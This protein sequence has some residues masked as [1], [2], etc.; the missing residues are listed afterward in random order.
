MLSERRGCRFFLRVA[1]RNQLPCPIPQPCP[2]SGESSQLCNGWVVGPHFLASRMC[3][4]I[5]VCI[6]FL[7]FSQRQLHQLF[8]ILLILL[9]I[10]FQHLLTVDFYQKTQWF[11]MRKFYA[12]WIYSRQCLVHL[13]HRRQTFF[14]ILTYFM[15]FHTYEFKIINLLSSLLLLISSFQTHFDQ[16]IL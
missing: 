15:S 5:H 16:S 13:I 9:K 3:T 14:L 1:C 7:N 11:S 6:L 12:I 10:N 8:S 2:S 4:H